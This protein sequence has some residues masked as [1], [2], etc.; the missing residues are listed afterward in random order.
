MY[1]VTVEWPWST[2]SVK[3]KMDVAYYL[4][5]MQNAMPAAF[6]TAQPKYSYQPY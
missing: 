4:K 3:E 2:S 6:T 1:P 5:E